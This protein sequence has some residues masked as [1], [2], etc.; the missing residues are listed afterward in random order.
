MINVFYY[1][2]FYTTVLPD[3]Q[4]RLTVVF[5]LSLSESFII[6]NLMDVVST[7]VY[8]ESLGKWPMLSAFVFI[9]V[10]N[11]FYFNSDRV[12]IIIEK[13]PKLVNHL[14]SVIVTVLFFAGSFSLMILVPL[15]LRTILYLGCAK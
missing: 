9:F 12:D 4:P 14:L 5:T 3:D 15:Y 11:Y 8:C 1:Y 7:V 10:F 2:L 13:K 6:N